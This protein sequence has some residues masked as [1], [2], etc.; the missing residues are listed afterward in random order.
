M[1][2]TI[3]DLLKEVSQE[4][5][6]ELSDLDGAYVLNESV[7]EDAI[8][9]SLSFIKSFIVLPQDP[10]PLLKKIA[11]DLAIYNLKQKNDLINDQD[12]EV[13]SNA[14]KYLSKMSKGSMPTTIEEQ[15]NGSKRDSSFAFKTSRRRIK[16][17]P[18]EY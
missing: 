1:E 7:V 5:L 8:S 11:I 9:D 15:D 2:I 12:K 14:E 10:T 3:D 18:G 16:R 6:I 13:R 17:R 4:Q